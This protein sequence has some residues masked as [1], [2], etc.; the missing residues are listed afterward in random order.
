[1]QVWGDWGIFLLLLPHFFMRTYSGYLI[2]LEGPEYAGK[3]TQALRIYKWLTDLGL[4]LNPLLARE[5]GG[6]QVG[7]A[8]GSIL[9]DLRFAGEISDLAETFLFQAARAQI[10][11]K[12][13][14]PALEEGRVVI[15]DRFV[16]SSRIYQ[17]EVRG[18]GRPLIETLN[19]ISTQ[20]LTPDTTFLLDLP[21][22]ETLRRMN[23]SWKLPERIDREQADFHQG[24]REAYLR[25]FDLD[26]TILKRWILID[27]NRSED[28]VFGELQS[29]IES[30]L[31]SARVIE[32][33][34]LTRERE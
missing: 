7:E 33:R 1:M 34:I 20:G 4:G 3:T 31:L 2:T 8:I 21:V 26:N 24:I 28:E 16:D 11:E 19:E 22:E 32:R 5:P 27:A 13:V 18:L 17:G 25:L 23:L 12:M 15:L 30:R 9:R 29:Q 10:C 6:D 14:R